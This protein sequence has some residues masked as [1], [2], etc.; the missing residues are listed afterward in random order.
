[1]ENRIS[2]LVQQFQMLEH[3]EGGFYAP[4]FRS[5]QLLDTSTLKINRWKGPRNLYSSIYYLL[6]NGQF[7]CWHRIASDE[8]W[9]FYEGDPITL[10]VLTKDGAYYC[11]TLGNPS[12]DL[13]YQ[14]VV[15][16]GDWF[17]A[18]S[19]GPIGYSLTGCSLAP[20][21]DFADFEIGSKEMLLEQYPNQADVIRKFLTPT[22]L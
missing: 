3:P 13:C 19:S 21:F 15:K 14:W 17:A 12:S 5:D 9:H 20:G 7:S 4:A 18:I 2:L 22:H 1:M 10:H 11:K 8:M 16:G 6:M